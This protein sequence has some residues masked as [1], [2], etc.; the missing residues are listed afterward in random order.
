[1][2]SAKKFMGFARNQ[3]KKR[4]EIKVEQK[5][6]LVSRGRWGDSILV[7]ERTRNASY[8]LEMNMESLD[9]IISKLCD[10]INKPQDCPSFNRFRG[11]ESVVYMQKFVNVRGSYLEISKLVWRGKTQ[12]I[13]IPSGRFNGGWKWMASYL[14]RF[15]LNGRDAALKFRDIKRPMDQPQRRHH[16]RLNGGE[17]V[18]PVVVEK[19]HLPDMTSKDWDKAIII[20]RDCVNTSWE[21]VCNTLGK[22]IQRMIE[23]FPF[24]A[25]KAVWWPHNEEV[26]VFYLRLKKCF[27]ERNVTLSFQ[28]WSHNINREEEVSECCHSWIRVLGIPWDLWS[29]DLFISIG[30]QCGGLLSISQDTVLL[31]DLSAAKLKVVGIEGGFINRNVQI[32]TKRGPMFVRI[33]VD[34][35]KISEYDTLEKRTY[36]QVVMNAVSNVKGWGNKDGI[37][38]NFQNAEVSQDIQNKQ[39]DNTTNL[40]VEN[41]EGFIKN[42]Q[43]CESMEMLKFREN[44]YPKIVEQDVN[45][46]NR[47]CVSE[48]WYR[49]KNIKILK[50]LKPK[51]V[52][53]FQK[54]KI[55]STNICDTQEIGQH[56]LEEV[57]GPAERKFEHVYRRKQI[58]T[59]QDSDQMRKLEKSKISILD[60][61]RVSAIG[62]EGIWEDQSY[63]GA[64]ED[65]SED[66]GAFSDADSHI[67]DHSDKSSRKSMQFEDLGDFFDQSPLK[68]RN[69][70]IKSN[71]RS[72]LVILLL[73]QILFLSRGVG[74]RAGLS[75][76]I[77]QSLKKGV[78]PE[79]ILG[80]S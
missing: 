12:R 6:F 58:K 41:Q 61:D 9:W 23:V 14:S 54:G 29:R 35:V 44:I 40:S 31:R 36:A 38:D 69:L 70:P 72:I 64:K 32:K 49:G 62:E 76:E 48:P 55:D 30:D 1:M 80:T 42:K 37:N 3:F 13:I 75:G 24:Q 73:F 15:R 7:T 56:T 2:S 79:I 60:I 68:V 45:A 57:S 10:F 25:N 46:E 43:K 50:K 18:S 8:I 5:L 27:L 22:E 63:H 66:G 26:A 21:L 17:K 39:E 34:S 28:K 78:Y 71:P 59:Q 77:V 51:D 4:Y 16:V 11:R 67:S 20:T 33:I 74:W 47:R 65:S 52:H 19:E 53:D